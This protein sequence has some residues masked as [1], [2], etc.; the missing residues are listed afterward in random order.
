MT[1]FKQIGDRNQSLE[2]AR[3]T[4]RNLDFIIEA[5]DKNSVHVVTQSIMSLLGLVVFP[6]ERS[7]IDAVKKKKLPILSSQGWPKWDMTGKNVVNLGN[8]I[9]RLRDSVAH[10]KVEFDS[11]SPEPAEVVVKFSTAPKRQTTADWS[12]QI[13]G[14]H[15]IQFCRKFLTSLIESLD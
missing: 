7:A 3:R 12:G 1:N 11:D 15:L 13:R 10:G 4:M 9:K 5:Q 14:D 6:W 8:L 2:F